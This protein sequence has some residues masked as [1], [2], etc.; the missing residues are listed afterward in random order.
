MAPPTSGDPRQAWL[1]RA[2]ERYETPLLGYALRLLNGHQ[3]AAQDAVQE[4]FLRLCRAPSKR[5][6]GRLAPWLF[7]V[8]RNRVIDMKRREQHYTSNPEVPL[9]D[10]S[11]GPEQLVQEIDEVARLQRLVSGLPD[12]QRELLHLRLQV[13]LSYREIAE[14]TGLS[15][16]NVGYHLHA[17]VRSLREHLA[18]SSKNQTA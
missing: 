10:P 18:A 3:E 11:P 9:A 4:T 7:A 17:A 8:C 6:E 16:T 12:R 1:R 13:G 2:V 5:L 15:V 14:V